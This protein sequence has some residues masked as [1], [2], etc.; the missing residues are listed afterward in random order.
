MKVYSWKTLLVTIFVG[1][2]GLAYAVYNVCH[3]ATVL[4]V[5]WVVMFGVWLVRGL[6]ASLTEEGHAKNVENWKREK[7]VY[8]R[9]FGKF[10]PIMP[11]GVLIFF[12]VAAIFSRALPEQIW[13]C[14]CFIIAG[15]VY[16]IWLA[17]VVSREVER[18]KAQQEE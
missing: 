13:V 10:A 12:G 5:T 17:A 9:L 2:S 3:G 16:T 6:I 7:R 18:E 14:L 11:W 15:F 4:N 1:G 8:R